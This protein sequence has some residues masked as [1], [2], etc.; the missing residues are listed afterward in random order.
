M[1]VE[2]ASTQYTLIKS[3]ILPYVRCLNQKTAGHNGCMEGS[4]EINST[5][6]SINNEL[7]NE[8]I[9]SEILH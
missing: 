7:K 3:K 4:D 6:E 1:T 9:V 8:G 5:I 2:V